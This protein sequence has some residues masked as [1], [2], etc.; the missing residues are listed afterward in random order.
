MERKCIR[1]GTEMKEGYGLKID[2][3]VMAGMAP[4]HLSKG[5]GVMS[6]T[7]EKIKA[8]VCPECGEISLYIEK[9]DKL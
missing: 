2:N 8:A 1:C 3:L 9:T 6:G 4:V 7:L 5:Q